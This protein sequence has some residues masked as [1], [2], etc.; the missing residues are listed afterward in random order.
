MAE[1]TLEVLLIRLQDWLEVMATQKAGIVGTNKI[2][3]KTKNCLC[4]TLLEHFLKLWERFPKNI[5]SKY[6]LFLMPQNF[7]KS[8]FKLHKKFLTMNYMWE[9]IIQFI[10]IQSLTQKKNRNKM[11]SENAKTLEPT[12]L[13]IMWMTSLLALR[14]ISLMKCKMKRLGNIIAI[15]AFLS[16]F[17]F[18]SVTK[19]ACI[20]KY[21][22][23]S[24]KLKKEI[25]S[26]KA[27][28]M[29][30]IEQLACFTNG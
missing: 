26:C 30:K 25:W 22:W 2:S 10:L 24:K 11:T 4:T 21:S 1:S 7:Q 14:Q 20:R 16:I 5:I 18:F 15:A 9:M 13:A 6:V 28:E 19:F 29:Q 23:W 8:R 3:I 17:L 12:T 27:K